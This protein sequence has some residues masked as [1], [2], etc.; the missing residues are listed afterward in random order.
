VRRGDVPQIGDQPNF[1]SLHEIARHA[2]HASETLGVSVETLSNMASQQ[3]SVYR[4]ASLVAES[5][6]VSARQTQQ[7]MLFQLRM[8]KSLEARSKANEARLRNEITL[9]RAQP[10][11]Y[12]K[13]EWRN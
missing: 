4:E 7:Y 1:V 12:S 11:A 8:L 13:H 10:V 5:D 9:V 3:Q 6:K 2:I